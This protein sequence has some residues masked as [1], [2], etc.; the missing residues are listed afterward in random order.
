M[1]DTDGNP[2]R[3]CFDKTTRDRLAKL[4]SNAF[5]GR[6]LSPDEIELE[7]TVTLHT[8]E[9]YA[10]AIPLYEQIQPESQQRRRERIESL[11]AH[12][13][14]ALEQLKS[15]DSAALGFIAWR[16]KDE[17]SKTL[18]TP[19]DFPSGLKAA[20][21]AVSWREANISA[22]TAFAL[23]LRK[24]ASELPQ[25]SLNTSGKEYPWYS[26]PKELST[27]MAV[28]R[29]FWEN[30]FRFTIANSGLAA[31]CLRAVFQL[32]GLHIDRVDYW[33]KQARDHSDSMS[34]FNKRMQ[35]RNEE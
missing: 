11:A 21:E 27:A 16:A 24:S 34:S 15:L 32:G 10:S 9:Q 17:M 1:E 19:N 33:L 28:E 5:K 8:L 22:I 30:G 13:E 6:D 31:E 18:G 35:K 3:L 4:F 23:G 12:L 25:H 20:I 14:G 2:S 29:L 7:V 26:L